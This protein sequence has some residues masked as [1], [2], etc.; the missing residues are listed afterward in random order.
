MAL[1]V[2]AG[3]EPHHPVARPRHARGAEDGDGN[4]Q[5][6]GPSGPICRESPHGPIVSC[7][8]SPT[9]LRARQHRRFSHPPLNSCLAADSPCAT[10][11]RVRGA[12]RRRRQPSCG[13][14]HLERASRSAEGPRARQRARPTPP[15]W[16][17]LPRLARPH[18]P[19][20]HRRAPRRRPSSTLPAGHRSRVAPRQSG[21]CRSSPAHGRKRQRAGFEASSAQ[22]WVAGCRM[23]ATTRRRSPMACTAT[24]I[25]TSSAI[26]GSS[27]FA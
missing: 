6:K 23:S 2:G 1:S 16:L 15:S 4:D 22:V 5:R 27:Q 3:R 13:S 25:E 10:R 19:R 20:A 12:R 26:V 17:S 7:A 24:R 18:A 9:R 14:S 21:A 11:T 8:S